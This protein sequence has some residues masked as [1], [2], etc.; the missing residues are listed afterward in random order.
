MLYGQGERGGFRIGDLLHGHSVLSRVGS[1]VTFDVRQIIF[2][3]F[4][5]AVVA[6]PGD[7][8]AVAGMKGEVETLVVFLYPVATIA[9]TVLDDGFEAVVPRFLAGVALAVKNGA[10][11]FVVEVKVVSGVERILKAI[12]TGFALGRLL[13]EVV[14]L[15]FFGA[16]AIL[17]FILFFIVFQV[18]EQVLNGSIAGGFVA[19]H[20]TAGDLRSVARF[21]DKVIATAFLK[22]LVASFFATVADH[23]AD[24]A[25][26]AARIFVT[27]A[28]QN[29]VSRTVVEEVVEKSVI[30]ILVELEAFLAGQADEREVVQSEQFFG[31]QA[32]GN[33]D[34]PGDGSVFVHVEFRRS[35]GFITELL[36]GGFCGITAGE[37]GR[38]PKTAAVIVLKFEVIPAGLNTIALTQG[39]NGGLNGRDGRFSVRIIGTRKYG[40]AVTVP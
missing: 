16:P 15:R 9:G 6:R 10:S 26:P 23:R 25:D 33:R 19:E 40:P 12:E 21:D 32:F 2:H 35:G 39:G 4:V 5:V 8:D 34:F 1:E 27:T 18:I 28:H 24:V 11:T 37:F 3:E 7:L 29:G 14:L 31:T 13:G 38:T 17:L 20:G 30:R 36:G 22:A